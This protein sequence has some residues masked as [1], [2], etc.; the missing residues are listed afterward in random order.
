MFLHIYPDSTTPLMQYFNA[1][2]VKETASRITEVLGWKHININRMRFIR[3]RGSRSKYVL[4]RIHGFPKVFQKALS[5]NPHYIIEVIGE[6][7]D[8]LSPDE[9]EKTLI[10][11]LLHVPKG[12]QGG[13]LPH[14]NYI[15]KRKV[16]K[17]HKLYRIGKNK[18]ISI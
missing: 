1:S 8:L 11:E 14:K 16:E 5:M 2:D 4:A 7:Y 18:S 15:T 17:L 13:L 10:H 12:F 9:R 6:K 3:S